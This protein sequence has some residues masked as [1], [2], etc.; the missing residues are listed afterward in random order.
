MIKCPIFFLLELKEA[1]G[2]AQERQREA[3]L[4][5]LQSSSQL[6]LFISM[7]HLNGGRLGGEEK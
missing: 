7:P 2:D 6:P 5:V 4:S 1:E 3:V